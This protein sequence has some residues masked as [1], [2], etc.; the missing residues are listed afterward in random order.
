MA[1]ETVV[2]SFVFLIALSILIIL[3]ITGPASAFIS[4]LTILNN[5]VIRGG[6]V[7]IVAIVI[8]QNETLN[9][10]YLLLNLSA[11]NGIPVSVQCKFSSNGNI[12]SGCSGMTIKKVNASDQYGY[13]SLNALQYNIS[14]DTTNF[15]PAT[16]QTS[17][18]VVTVNQTSAQAGENIVI[19]PINTVLQG[20]CSVRAKDSLINVNGENF[21]NS[22]LN[23]YIPL[24]NAVTGQGY[25]LGQNQKETF[26]YEFKDAQVLENND[27]DMI[28]LLISGNYRLGLGA[29]IPENAVVMLNK[30]NKTVSVIGDKVS[31]LNMIVTFKDG[32]K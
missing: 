17:L 6:L 23:F 21:S 14:I 5:Q 28:L 8:P 13:L 30:V 18:V 26:N 1:K 29:K 15:I 12:I 10:N 11:R 20:S 27:Q 22:R 3:I 32:C 19:A 9:P 24:K 7:N 16:Y 2:K 25:L 31:D 4:G